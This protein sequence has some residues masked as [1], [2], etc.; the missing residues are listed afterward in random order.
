[1]QRGGQKGQS[2]IFYRRKGADLEKELAEIFVLIDKKDVQF[3]Y[4]EL[5]NVRMFIFSVEW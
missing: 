2:W 3:R 4:R 1:M 5:L